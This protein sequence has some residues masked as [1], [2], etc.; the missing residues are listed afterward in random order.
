MEWKGWFLD[1]ATRECSWPQNERECVTLWAIGTILSSDHEG[2]E[3]FSAQP[4]IRMKALHGDKAI[5]PKLAIEVH[6]KWRVIITSIGHQS[7]SRNR[8]WILN[9]LIWLASIGNRGFE[10]KFISLDPIGMSLWSLD[11]EMSPTDL[12]HG[13]QCR[14][15]F[16]SENTSE[17]ALTWEHFRD[18]SCSWMRN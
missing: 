8:M 11:R 5:H 15:I 18:K 10:C 1:R 16:L 3:Y 12:P 9:H 17:I 14:G 13:G 2:N 4:L 7:K 6:L